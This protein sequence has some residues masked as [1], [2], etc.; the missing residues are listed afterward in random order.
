MFR[1]RIPYFLWLH[2]VHLFSKL[3]GMCNICTYVYSPRTHTLISRSFLTTTFLNRVRR[4]SF[5][6]LVLNASLPFCHCYYYYY[7]HYSHSPL[8]S[9]CTTVCPLHPSTLFVLQSHRL[10]T[11]HIELGGNDHPTVDHTSSY[12]RP[13][14]TPRRA[15]HPQRYRPTHGL[16]SMRRRSTYPQ[17]NRVGNHKFGRRSVEN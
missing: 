5:S 8:N 11:T 14:S 7:S 9:T 13:H 10:P 3:H 6:L 1:C 16:D 15:D 17:C 12:Y 2:Y 4:C